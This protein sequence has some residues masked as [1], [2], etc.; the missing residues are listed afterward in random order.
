MDMNTD[1]AIEL[2]RW[3][4]GG[5]NQ[6]MNLW[7]CMNH[8]ALWVTIVIVLCS[9]IILGYLKIAFHWYTNLKTLS[10]S[11]AK[12]SLF[13]MV[14]I[15]LFCGI[16]GYLFPIIKF[17]WPI[18]RLYAFFL[19]ILT[20]FTWRY[21]LNTPRLKVVYQEINKSTDLKSEL[22]HQKRINVLAAASAIN[23]IEP[24]DKIAKD[25]LV[26]MD[27][28]TD[29]PSKQRM[30]NVKAQLGKLEKEM[31]A[32]RHILLETRETSK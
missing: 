6:Y 8:D 22:D 27:N 14:N 3:F 11:L 25:V 2:M 26:E 10:R 18:W 7:H 16:C 29:E 19:A 31:H 30:E 32:L 24:I 20:F 5:D 1:S 13:N 21:A 12:S 15:F 28:A 9:A 23:T 17:W 4:S